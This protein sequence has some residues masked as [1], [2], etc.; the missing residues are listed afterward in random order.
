LRFDTGGIPMPLQSPLIVGFALALTV[1]AVAFAQDKPAVV[2]DP[3]IATMTNEQLVDAR[4]SAMKQ[5]GRALRGADALTG[6]QAV[7]AATILLQNFTSFP[8]LFREGSITDKS[9]A[10]PDIWENW[11]DFQARFAHD[12]EAAGR[13][14]AAAQAGDTAAYQVAV[15]EIGESC[16]ACH[17]TYRAR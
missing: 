16:G 7:A 4:Q 17:M 12:A 10:R 8:A 3:A 9:K 2:V 5:D 1:A 6:E 14:L 13:M 11:D 15:K